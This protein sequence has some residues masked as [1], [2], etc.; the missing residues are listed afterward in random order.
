MLITR[1][2]RLSLALRACALPPAPC[3]L[4]TSPHLRNNTMANQWDQY[5]YPTTNNLQTYER[6]V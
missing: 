1:S 5:K 6:V 4:L 3:P 2:A